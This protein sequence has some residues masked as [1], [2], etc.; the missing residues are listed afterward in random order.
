[1]SQVRV[2]ASTHELLKLL[3][4]E[5]GKS[6]QEIIDNAVADYRRNAFLRGLNDDFRALRQNE[7][8]WQEHKADISDWEGTISDGLEEDDEG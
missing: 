7:S 6:M 4:N 1:M 5:A 8:A 3:A 2:S